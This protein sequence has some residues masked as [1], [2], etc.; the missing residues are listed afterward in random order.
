MVI[1][2]LL[3]FKDVGPNVKDTPLP[4]HGGENVVNMVAG[5]LGDFQIFYINMVRGDLVKMHYDLCEFNYYTHD[6]VACSVC[7]TNVHGCDK[8]KSDL[9]EMMDE[10][11]IHIIRPRDVYEYVNM[12]EDYDVE[13]K[14]PNEFFPSDKFLSSD[15]YA[16]A[17]E[18]DSD[19]EFVSSNEFF[20]LMMSL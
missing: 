15:E 13:S 14:T 4:K 8:V 11:F 18:F 2:G 17:D 6:H 12:I 20:F 3:S 1:F 10:G 19:D 9:Q 7:S 16:S 5:C